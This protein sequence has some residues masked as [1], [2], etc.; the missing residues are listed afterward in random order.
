MT[1]RAELN[2]R[3]ALIGLGGLGVA[4]LSGIAYWHRDTL[5]SIRSEDDDT[6]VRPPS[7][8]KKP[9]SVPED[10]KQYEIQI[11]FPKTD[12]ERFNSNSVSFVHDG[13]WVCNRG[14]SPADIWIDSDAIENDR[15][16]LSV[17]FYRDGHLDQRIDA[18]ERAVTLEMDTCLRVGYMVR[19][20]GISQD[21][22]LL[23]SIT[24]RT[25]RKS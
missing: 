22:T 1:E 20:F 19:T 7:D 14:K 10:E 5:V 9:D 13:F 12:A 23:E 6:T 24:V 3:Q 21:T 18:P 4:S 15:G 25:N 17:W 16:E 2:R 11:Q 8:G